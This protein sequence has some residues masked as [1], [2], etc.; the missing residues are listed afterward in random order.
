MAKVL[1]CPAC[2]IPLSLFTPREQTQHINGCL[3]AQQS[4]CPPVI[5]TLLPCCIC[6]R[7]L[8]AL[9]PT[10]RDEH[11][12]RCVDNELP[13]GTEPVSNRGGRGRARGRG[14]RRR[15]EDAPPNARNVA[16]RNEPASKKRCDPQVVRLLE[17]LGLGRYAKNFA[18]EE[19]DMS[20]LRLLRENDL[21]HLRLPDSARRRIAEA[22]RSVPVLAGMQTN[23]SAAVVQNN[24][25]DDAIEATQRFGESRLGGHMR[26]GAPLI[27][28]DGSEDE[29]E[30]TAA[31]GAPNAEKV[32]TSEEPDATIL[33]QRS[34]EEVPT[35][36][37]ANIECPV[38]GGSPAGKT[39]GELHTA[40]PGQMS[41][42]LES[43]GSSTSSLSSDLGD[44]DA[45]W[46][47]MSQISAEMKL[48]RWQERLEAREKQRHESEVKR[49]H[50]IFE[51]NLAKL[52]AQQASDIQADSLPEST[53]D[54]QTNSEVVAPS[55]EN[56][57]GNTSGAIDLTECAS[58][59]DDLASRLRK[60]GCAPPRF[61]GLSIV[62]SSNDNTPKAP[63]VAPTVSPLRHAVND[64]RETNMPRWSDS[65][66]SLV[67]DI[68]DPGQQ[69]VG[70]TQAE[71]ESSQRPESPQRSQEGNDGID[72]EAVDLISDGNESGNDGDSQVPSEDSE[73][74][75]LRLARAERDN[76]RLPSQQE[77]QAAPTNSQN[78]KD[79]QKKR[80]ADG[81]CVTSSQPPTQS[82][83]KKRAK[84]LV[85]KATREDIKAIIQGNKTLY[86]D[87]LRMQVV[88]FD[89]VLQ[90][91]RSS[92]KS[93]SKKTMYDFLTREGILF[94]GDPVSAGS[95]NL[96][97]FKALSSQPV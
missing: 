38:E 92:G 55:T 10:A 31:I 3:D 33:R 93:V 26:R 67:I 12:N 14:G 94:K 36:G 78:T 44:F 53:N 52:R 85:P 35:V 48:R 64:V 32:R 37:G 65:E 56:R 88:S 82:R 72:G 77:S 34:T 73:Q 51:K 30:P 54:D 6:H 47:G 49:I 57:L 17:M 76:F 13:L 23:E 41:L 86:E 42:R 63:T 19:V 69:R 2:N 28:E 70:T 15:H 90:T 25:G 79:A 24:S 97:Y 81:G 59:D 66:D 84:V 61:A 22:M 58:D 50:D 62:V 18:D 5:E 87:I 95:A 16:E 4:E 75:F 91:V 39:G 8:T 83:L 7:D 29:Y 46:R 68:S 71:D 40:E 60:R 89:V 45:R 1:K 27:G 43:G 20:A 80:S 74:E 96:E 11:V 9:T 21:V